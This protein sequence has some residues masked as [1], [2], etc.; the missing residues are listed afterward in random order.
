MP[1]E[2]A[3]QRLAH[4]PLLERVAAQHLHRRERHLVGL[5]L[6]EVRERRPGAAAGHPVVHQELRV[7]VLVREVEGL[8]RVV[9]GRHDGLHG[10]EVSLAELHDLREP[11]GR[12]L[13][14]VL[15]GP[16]EDHPEVAQ[17]A[18]QQGLQPAQ[19]HE[20]E[21]L[22]VLREALRPRRRQDAVDVH[23]RGDQ[24]R[25][26]GHVRHRPGRGAGLVAPGAEDLVLRGEVPA[27]VLQL[28]AD[29]V[30]RHVDELE[31]RGAVHGLVQRELDLAIP[32]LQV[33]T[34]G[35]RQRLRHLADRPLWRACRSP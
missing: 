16:L 22:Q 26:C 9:P 34:H 20:E 29:P 11:L 12:A 35:V 13:A 31:E 28:R 17:L 14:E 2:G 6:G 24:R 4:V 30:S 27:D 18:L 23:V 19:A 21:Q 5:P 15:R 1:Q 33:V 7:V 32:L 10:A 3:E 8:V 25:G